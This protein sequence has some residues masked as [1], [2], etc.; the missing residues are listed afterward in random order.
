[1]WYQQI[2][3]IYLT[4]T[5]S[6]TEVLRLQQALK[7]GKLAKAGGD[8]AKVT[9]VTDDGRAYAQ[10]GK[11]YFSDLTVDPTTGQVT[12]RAELPNPKGELLPGMYVRVRVEQ[13]QASNAITLPQ[14][15]VTRTQQ[16]DTVNVVGEDGK[17][18]P[19][20]VKVTTA[21][22]NRWLVQE[23]LQ[24]GEQVMVDGFQKLQMMPPGTPV[25]AVPWQPPGAAPATPAASPASAA[26]APAA[27]ASQQ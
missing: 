15:A 21:Q 26:S 13:A 3:P 18:S 8:A 5:Q 27:P 22:N 11:L 7:D 24:A 6:S 20:T 19:R 23:G 9:L 1:M 14:Q 16:G 17:V 12:L 4:F 10:P 25:K 2:D